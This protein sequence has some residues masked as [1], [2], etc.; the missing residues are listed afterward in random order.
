MTILLQ[1]VV[2]PVGQRLPSPTLHFYWLTESL[3]KLTYPVESRKL[4]DEI[5]EK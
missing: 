5:L 2:I 1:G 4:V 3:L